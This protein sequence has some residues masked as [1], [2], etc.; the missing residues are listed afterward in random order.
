MTERVFAPWV[1]PIAEELGHRRADV[2]AFARSAPEEIWERPSGVDDWT[3][4]DIM[5]HLAAGTGKQHQAL[6]RAV[7]S[8][9]RVDP[10]LFGNAEVV[11]G[12]DVEERRAQSIDTIIAEYEADTEELLDLLA[13]L[14]E[15]DQGR[16]QKGFDQTFG[17]ALPIFGRHELEHLTQLRAAAEGIE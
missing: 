14:T 17:E 9:T 5:S 16:R 15:E 7:L 12:R 11:N 13:Q 3:C 4:K 8:N 10:N 6:V 2:S 1:Q